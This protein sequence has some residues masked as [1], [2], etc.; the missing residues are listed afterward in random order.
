M[1]WVEIPDLSTFSQLLTSKLLS[2]LIN[3]LK[4]RRTPTQYVFTRDPAAGNKALTNTTY[5]DWDAGSTFTGTFTGNVVEV[6]FAIGDVTLAVNLVLTLLVDNVDIG[7][8]TT[9]LAIWKTT[10]E[11]AFKYLITGLAA[12]SHTI[13]LQTKNASAGTV[14]FNSTRAMQFWVKEW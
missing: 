7:I 8:S 11:H 4:E 2:D 5:A 6:G 3:N 1:A 14:T 10:D 9:G 13:K 12:G